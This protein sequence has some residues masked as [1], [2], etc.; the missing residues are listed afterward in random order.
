MIEVLIDVTRS[1]I[2][3]VGVIGVYVLGV[4]WMVWELITAPENEYWD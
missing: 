2:W 3:I 4:I 1:S